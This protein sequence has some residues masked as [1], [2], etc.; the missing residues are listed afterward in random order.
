MNRRDFIKSLIALP[1]GLEIFSLLDYSKFTAARL[2]YEGN[3]DLRQNALR[4]IMYEVG[5]RTS[6]SCAAEPATVRPDDTAIFNYPFLC[7]SGNKALPDFSN[8]SIA[9]LKRFINKGGFIFIDSSEENGEGFYKSVVRLAGQI[10]PASEFSVIKEENVIYK[11][12]YMLTRAYGRLN[13]QDLFE[14]IIYESRVAI[15]F[16][17]NDLLGALEKD[18]LGNYKFPIPGEDT[19][20]E[21]CIRTAVNIVMYSLCVDYKD[22]QVHHPFFKEKIRR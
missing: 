15:L 5:R 1:A 17:H 14:G 18:E 13:R 11:T 3:W 7:I 20:R 21:L 2:Q 8:I 4:R 10:L 9:R 12:F 16:S 6:I 22:D 19:R